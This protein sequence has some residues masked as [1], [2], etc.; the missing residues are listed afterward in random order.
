[1]VSENSKRVITYLQGI[2]DADVTAQDVA[3]ALGLGVKSVVGIFTSAIQRK[4]YGYRVPV[5]VQL[6]D[7]TH[8]KTNLLKLNDAG[9]ALDVNAMDKDAE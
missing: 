7:G 9:K 3:D 5:E 2:G 8:K 1:M 6:D 4:D